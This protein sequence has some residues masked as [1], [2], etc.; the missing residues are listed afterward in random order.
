MQRLI[1]A[2]AALIPILLAFSSVW[3]QGASTQAV[4][5]ARKIAIQK[6]RIKFIFF[7]PDGSLVAT[8]SSDGIVQVF[9]VSKGELQATITG[10]EG[11]FLRGWS[12]DG[13]HLVI[14]N[15]KTNAIRFGEARS[16]KLLSAPGG[17]RGYPSQYL[18][19]SVG[20]NPMKLLTTGQD[21]KVELWDMKT[22]KLI[23]IFEHQPMRSASHVFF[24]NY[25]KTIVTAAYKSAPKLWDAAT[26]KLIATLIQ[27]E[28]LQELLNQPYPPC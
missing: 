5:Q 9:D 21:A 3:A 8:D 15:F 24:A 27:P 4:R 7:S 11:D 16:G 18:W 17:Y 1:L 13:K 28:A 10:F 22:N 2:P 26:G 25:G 20:R 6:K 19:D 23:F 12:P 14:G